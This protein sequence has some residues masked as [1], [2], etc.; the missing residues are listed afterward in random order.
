MEKDN[1]FDE[2]NNPITPDLKKCKLYKEV[3]HM[4][5][6]RIKAKGGKKKA[7]EKRPQPQA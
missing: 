7:P 5:E 2:Y 6:K 1:I 4:N 3:A